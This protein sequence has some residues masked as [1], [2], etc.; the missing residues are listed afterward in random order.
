M[1]REGVSKRNICI[2]Y[3]GGTASEPYYAV[4]QTNDY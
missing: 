1:F 2:A 3:L 4:T